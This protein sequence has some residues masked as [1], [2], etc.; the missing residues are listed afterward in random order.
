LTP[1]IAYK[2]SMYYEVMVRVKGVRSKGL[3]KVIHGRRKKGYSKREVAKV[4]NVERVHSKEIWPSTGTYVSQ[5]R[6]GPRFSWRVRLGRKG[7]EESLSGKDER[8]EAEAAIFCA[9]DER[10]VGVE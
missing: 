2:S 5:T 9:E 1:G 3:S 8:C 4:K 6:A 10:E 7:A